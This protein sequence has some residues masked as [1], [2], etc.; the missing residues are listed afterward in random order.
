MKILFVVPK[1]PTDPTDDNHFRVQHHH[2]EGLSYTTCII[3]GVQR[4]V[5]STSRIEVVP[6]FHKT[7]LVHCK[8]LKRYE[9]PRLR[10]ANIPTVEVLRYIG[11]HEIWPVMGYYRQW[12][13]ASG[14]DEVRLIKRKTDTLIH[15]G[16]L[17]QYN[18][19]GVFCECQVF[20][21]DKGRQ[22]LQQL[23]AQ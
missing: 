10:C 21:T 15:K 5:Y 13:N 17:T 7:I 6:G 9:I 8:P 1:L 3:N 14:F 23:E 20:L 22:R 2:A 16:Y 4:F 18:A 12:L 11:D 19:D